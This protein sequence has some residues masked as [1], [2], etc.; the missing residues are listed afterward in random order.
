MARRSEPLQLRVRGRTVGDVVDE[1]R[2]QRL[3]GRVRLTCGEDGQVRITEASRSNP[4]AFRGQL[5]QEG[6]DTVLDGEVRETRLGRFNDVLF[7]VL[8]AFMTAVAVLLALD[9]IRDEAPAIALCGVCALLFL[10][11]V[12]GGRKLRGRAFA[13][14]AELYRNL[15]ATRLGIEPPM[16]VDLPDPD[17]EDQ[18]RFSALSLALY[19]RL[20]RGALLRDCAAEVDALTDLLTGQ[21][22]S[23]AEA[24]QV[25]EDLS[26][27]FAKS[28][29]E[30]Q[31]QVLAQLRAQLAL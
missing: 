15:L 11:L 3:R 9:N 24:G 5:R 27:E 4:P 30:E 22:F 14:Q 18:R 8:A 2:A 10:G 12:L 20:H 21:G 19:D 1:L 29:S 25:V 6:A 26:V 31:E 23:R 16:P 7:V 28:S 13:D 17:D